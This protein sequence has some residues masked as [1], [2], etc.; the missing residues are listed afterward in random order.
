MAKVND[1]VRFLNATGG[2]RVS[3]IEGN[4]AYVE[5][6]DGFEQPV[7]LREC[8]VV[9]ASKPK[10]TAYDRPITPAPSKE[11]K[12]TAAPQPSQLPLIE[13]PEG[14]TLN[15]LLAYEPQEPRHIN[16]TSFHAYLVNDSNY[17][18]YVAYMTRGDNDSGTWSTR[19]HGIVEPNIQVLLEEFHHSDLPEM[20]RVAVQY[21][22]FKHGKDF[23]LKNPALVEHRLDTTKFY[24]IH[25]FHDCEYFDSP[26]IALDVVRND[27]PAK[28]LVIDSGELERAMQLKRSENR[29]GRRP[30]E[31]HTKNKGEIIECDLHIAELIDTTA[32]MSNA[33]MLQLQLSKFHEVMRDNLRRPG[34]KVVFIHGKG[35]G[36]LRKALL[37]ELRRKYPRCEAQDA[38]FREYGFGATLV[39]IH[40]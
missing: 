31:K 36:V 10:A 30:V 39:K 7:L 25:C 12:K 26:V 11:E 14:E 4:V 13:T 37:D 38:S 28:Q 18:L 17:Y 3:R 1:I 22:A 33:D 9:D 34:A 2:G 40:P 32:G 29:P 16:T 8:V 5:D 23:K 24:K 20:S 27:R 19:F 6:A 15:V 21:I 35:E